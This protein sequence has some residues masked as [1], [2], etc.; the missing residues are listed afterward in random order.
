MLLSDLNRFLEH[1]LSISEVLDVLERIGVEVEDVMTIGENFGRIIPVKVLGVEKVGNL[2]WVEIRVD[3]DKVRTATTDQVYVGETLL[4]ADVPPKKFGDRISY[5]MFI[6]EEELGLSPKSENLIRVRDVETYKEDFLIGD[7]LIELYITPNR[8]DLFGAMWIAKE[9]SLF[10]G[11]AF[12][13]LNLR[14]NPKDTFSFEIDISTLGCDLYTIRKIRLGKGKT[15]DVIRRKLFLVGFNPINPAVDATNWVSYIVGQPLHAFDSRKVKGRIRV[16]ESQGGETFISLAGEKY[17]LPPGI[18]CIADEEKILALGGV[19]G[20]LE[21]GTY[22]DTEEILLESAHFLPEYIRKAETLTGIF[23]ESSRRFEKNTSPHLVELGS[24]YAAELLKEWCGAE[25]T[26]ILKSGRVKPQKEIEV[27]LK[28]FNIYFP[29]FKGDVK[30]ILEKLEFS[31]VPNGKSI[32]VRPPIHRTDIS[33]QEDVF[34][35]IARFIGYDNIPSKPSPLAPLPP[36]PR[37]R[38]YDEILTFLSSKGGY[39]VVSLGLF[40]DREVEGSK[41]YEITSGFNES[42]KYLST[43][44]IPHILK[45]ISYNLRLGNPPKP[46]FS[47]VRIYD[48]D[49]KVYIIMGAYKPMKYSHIKGFLD[50]LREKFGWK[51]DYTFPS[52]DPYL[53]PSASADIFFEN[54]KVGAAGTVRP[55][56]ARVFGIKREVYVWYIEVLPPSSAVKR[57]I[58]KL[59]ASFKDIS[60]LV[61]RDTKYHHIERTI[62]GICKKFKEVEGWQLM[63]IYTGKNIPEGTISFTFRFIIRPLEKS[64]TEEEINGIFSQIRSKIAEKYKIRG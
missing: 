36:S 38:I 7:S 35:E 45:A 28:K 48:P 57:R 33:F 17:T 39:Q 23:T 53:H 49:E 15:P 42:F 26:N 20:G 40:S 62:E 47:L 16:I 5:G 31:I 41:G 29:D 10:S 54:R 34:E 18:I 8:P 44:P 22:E 3:G 64:L 61:P 14:E 63:D 24:L 1:E 51:Y 19:I 11:V 46:L 9:I 25:Y 30:D 55:K 52:D 56:K 6:S 13:G 2:T 43:S 59:P 60:I 37:D 50:S 12:K 58:S 21:S 32:K 4:W 27:N